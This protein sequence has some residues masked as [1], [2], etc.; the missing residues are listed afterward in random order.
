[1]SDTIND[2]EKA[3]FKLG[4]ELLTA[5]E[6]KIL[7]F[8]DKELQAGETS[9]ADA[10]AKGIKAHVPIVGATL[11]S[12]LTSVLMDLEHTAEGAL[13]TGFDRLIADLEARAAA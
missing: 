9:V 10:L 4:A 2:L 5:N 8:G 3:G 13:K 11:A 6:D 7:A 1:M 12:T